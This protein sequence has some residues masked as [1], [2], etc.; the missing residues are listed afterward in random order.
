MSRTELGQ[1]GEFGLIDRINK[2][3]DVK[4]SSTRKG[5]GDD[6]AAIQSE[7][8]KLTLVS[9]DMLVEGIHFDLASTLEPHIQGNLHNS[10]IS[11]VDTNGTLFG[12]DDPLDNC[13]EGQ[14]I[15]NSPGTPF[16]LLSPGKSYTI[17]VAGK[18]GTTGDYE[19]RIRKYS[20]AQSQIGNIYLAGSDPQCYFEP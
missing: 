20:V 6:A 12:C 19:L 18:G 4:N 10:A 7:T 16:L 3:T 1:L 11:S 17:I 8:G 14:A 5:I 13:D 2:Q 9:T 15:Y